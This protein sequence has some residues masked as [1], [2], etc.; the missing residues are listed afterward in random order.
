MFKLN[1]DSRDALRK[2]ARKLMKNA[3]QDMMHDSAHIERTLKISRQ[4]F[5]SFDDPRKNWDIVEQAVLWHDIS[6]TNNHGAGLFMFFLD[7][8]LSARIIKKEFKKL[9]IDREFTNLICR[10]ILEHRIYSLSKNTLNGSVFNDADALDMYS[11]I[12][13]NRAIKYLKNGRYSRKP[14]WQ[15]R[16]VRHILNFYGD[17]ALKF[18]HPQSYKKLNFE[19]SKRIYINKMKNLLKFFNANQDMAKIFLTKEMIFKF[20]KRLKQEARGNLNG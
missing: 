10:I 20:R 6:R 7:D 15:K 12:R 5:D 2:R 4:I 18:Y 14:E 11:P 3:T 16:F 9:N 19:E 13:F 17:L 1:K 8:L